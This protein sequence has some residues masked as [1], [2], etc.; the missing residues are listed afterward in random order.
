MKTLTIFYDARCGLCAKFRQWLEAQ[1]KRVAVHFLP[2]DSPAAARLFPGLLEIG[3][4][5]DVVVLA[6]DGRWWQ[7]SAAWLTCLWATREYRTWSFRLAAPVFQPL[8]RKAVHLLSEN[9]LALSRLFS[10]REDWKL[11]AALDSATSPQC[12][13]G[14]CKI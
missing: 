3:A 4:D 6:D 13:D 8:V 12:E 7:G 11:A 2:F 5:K 9:R 14:N 10:V 1:P